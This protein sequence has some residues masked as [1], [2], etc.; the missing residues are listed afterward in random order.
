MLYR[1]RPHRRTRVREQAFVFEDAGL[2]RRGQS[3]L[4]SAGAPQL[5]PVLSAALVI[6]GEV[7]ELET[8]RFRSGRC[9]LHIQVVHRC[10]F[11]LAHRSAPLRRLQAKCLVGESLELLRILGRHEGVRR[12]HWPGAMRPIPIL[13]LE[14]LA[15]IGTV[16]ELLR[17]FEA[18]V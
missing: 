17:L 5:V 18:A 9:W 16:L 12:L 7:G 4:L 8:H 2:R 3:A 13:T 1:R 11:L 10:R 15:V 6:E 14:P